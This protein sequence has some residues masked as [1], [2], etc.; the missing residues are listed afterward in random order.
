[1][2]K[3]NVQIKFIIPSLLTVLCIIMT[4]FL[5]KADVI[6]A[7]PL[8][9]VEHQIGNLLEWSTVFEKNSR[10]FIIEKSVNGIDFTNSGIIDAAGSSNLDKSYR[11]LDVG[12][13]D[14]QLYYRLK[15]IDADGTSSYSE[16]IL[17]EKQ[18]SNQFMIV[19]MS[20]TVTNMTFD[21]TIDALNTVDLAYT[22]KNKEGELISEDQQELYSGLNDI[23]LDLKDEKEGP[24]F[25]SLRVDQEEE[26]L[27]IQKVDDPIKKKA[28]IASKQS[29]KGG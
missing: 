18:M 17:I 24:Y 10:T 20:N 23:Q 28:N 7:V 5:A 6:Y 16:I 9:G 19:A 2:R 25:V 11:F 26:K 29:N 3:V 14:D 13:N 21:I 15:Q 1:M 4:S 12:V 8:K 27:V 22:I